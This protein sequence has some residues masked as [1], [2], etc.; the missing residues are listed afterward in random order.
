MSDRLWY[1]VLAFI[2][3]TAYSGSAVLPQQRSGVASFPR[4]LNPGE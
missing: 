3:D 2:R 4:V 1:F